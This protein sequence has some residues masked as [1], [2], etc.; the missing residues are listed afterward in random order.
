MDFSNLINIFRLMQQNGDILSGM[1]L[2]NFGR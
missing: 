1:F 2:I